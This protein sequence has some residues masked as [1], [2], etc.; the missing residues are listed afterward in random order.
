M[1]GE[2]T[3]H[4]KVQFEES[5]ERQRTQSHVA[6]NVENFIFRDCRFGTNT[7]LNCGQED[8]FAHEC[9]N[10]RKK[11]GPVVGQP[12]ANARVYSLNE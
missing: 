9:R 5:K 10:T 2:V 1:T 12:R 4:A 8:H 6:T 11:D 3:D 7:C